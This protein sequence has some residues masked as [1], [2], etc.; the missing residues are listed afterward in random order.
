[1]RITWGIKS[2]GVDCQ[3]REHQITL[4]WSLVSGKAHLYI[5]NKEIYRH[6]P[7]SDKIFNPFT[8]QFHKGF[9]LPNSKYNGHH[10][11]NIHCYSCI[12]LGNSVQQVGENDD[13]I[14][15]GEISVNNVA[16]GVSQIAVMQQFNLDVSVS[17]NDDATTVSF[18]LPIQSSG[19]A[20]FQQQQFSPPIGQPCQQQPSVQPTFRNP[21]F[22][23]Y[24][25]MSTSHHGGF[26]DAASFAFA[27][28]PTWDDYN[29]A[30]GGNVSVNWGASEAGGSI[31]ISMFDPIR[32]DPF[33]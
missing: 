26:N 20:G 17:G 25:S 33:A 22:N 27:P 23:L 21:T 15:F 30:F 8:A 4:L 18:M 9:N 1:M 10:L 2:V 29:N 14:D 12:P 24:S 7:P 13:L 32:Q 28:P 6:K 19:F 3:G 5:N 11:I 31:S 16:Q